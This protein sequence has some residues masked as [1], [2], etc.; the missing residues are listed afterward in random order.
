MRYLLIWMRCF[1]FGMLLCANAVQAQSL[2]HDPMRPLVPTSPSGTLLAAHDSAV[3]PL[4]VEDIKPSGNSIRMLVIGRDRSFAVMDGQLL[5]PGNSF[6]HWKLLSIGPQSVVMRNAAS[7]QVIDI[8]PGVI[9]TPRI[10]SS[11][12][13][14]LGVVNP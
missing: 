6:K 11:D 13:K 4:S 5:E 9:K 8:N 12:A 10:S 1:A 3:A 2:M 7:T 14:T